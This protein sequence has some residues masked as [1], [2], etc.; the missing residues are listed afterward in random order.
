MPTAE[1]IEVIAAFM[2]AIAGI[3][4][5]LLENVKV[6]FI[7]PRWPESPQ[8]AAILRLVNYLSNF[9][10]LVAVL[11][12]AHIFNGNLILVYLAMAFGQSV[13]GHVAYSNLSGNAFANKIAPKAGETQRNGATEEA[14]IVVEPSAP[15]AQTTPAVTPPSSGAKAGQPKRM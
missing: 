3:V 13:G 4:A 12:G 10:I 8:R 15:P 11:L 2:V 5:V 7:D 1:E 6:A 14:A 9:V